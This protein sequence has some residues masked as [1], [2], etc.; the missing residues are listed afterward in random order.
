MDGEADSPP[1]KKEKKASTHG[2]R[3]I[4][5][6]RRKTKHTHTGEKTYPNSLD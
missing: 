1:N 5:K 6:P 3:F 2:M 4:S